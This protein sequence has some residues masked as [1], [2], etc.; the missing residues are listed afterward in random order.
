MIDAVAMVMDSDDD[1]SE[2]DEV[3][4]SVVEEGCGSRCKARGGGSTCEHGRVRY[5]CKGAAAIC[6]HGRARSRCKECGGK[7]ICEHGRVR[8]VCKE[9][10]RASSTG[11]CAAL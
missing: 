4:V 10:A 3:Q 1:G 8:S 11:R 9:A 5:V 2:Y 7:G 6:E